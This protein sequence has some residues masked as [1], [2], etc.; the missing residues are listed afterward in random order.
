MNKDRVYAI[1]DYGLTII[2]SLLV[3]ILLFAEFSSE[4]PL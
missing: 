3:G 2:L 1:V 4:T